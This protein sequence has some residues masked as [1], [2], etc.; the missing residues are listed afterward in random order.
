MLRIHILNAC[1]GPILRNVRGVHTVG[2][3]ASRHPDSNTSQRK[4]L[5]VKLSRDRW[6]CLSSA[7]FPLEFCTCIQL[8]VTDF[9]LFHSQTCT[10]TS[11]SVRAWSSRPALSSSSR[12]D[13]AFRQPSCSRWFNATASAAPTAIVCPGD[14]SSHNLAG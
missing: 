11:S 5:P 10:P 7:L 14:G 2:V 8:R 4:R 12:L 1:S 3:D 9:P 13:S 6:E